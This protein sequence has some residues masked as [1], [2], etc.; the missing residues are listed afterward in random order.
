MSKKNK[1]VSSGAIAKI[2]KEGYDCPYCGSA[3][4]DYIFTRFNEKNGGFYAWFNDCKHAVHARA[5]LPEDTKLKVV[6][7]KE[8]SLPEGVNI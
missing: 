2:A 3:D 7:F 6:D 8:L 1:W 4:V 5:I